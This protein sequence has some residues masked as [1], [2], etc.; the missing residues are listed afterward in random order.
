MEPRII[1]RRHRDYSEN[2]LSWRRLLDAYV[3]GDQYRN[4]TYGTDSRGLPIYNLV[5]HK[6]EYPLPDEI[7]SGVAMFRPSGSD[8]YAIATT[9]DFEFRRA[10]TP[11]PNFVGDAVELHLSSIYDQEVRR[12]VPDSVKQWHRDVN[13]RRENIDIWMSNT[14][15]PMVLV[16]GQVDVLIGH[17]VPSPGVSI[18]TRADELAAGLDRLVISV[19]LPQNV[20]WW[21]TDFW[22]NYS[23]VTILETDEATGENFVRHWHATG[24]TLYSLRNQVVSSA[25]YG[26]GRPPIIR[27][28]AKRDPIR[29]NI[30]IS[31]YG[32]VAD[33]MREYYNRDSELVLSDTVQAHPLVQGPEKYCLPDSKIPIGPNW[34]LPKRFEVSGGQNFYEGWDV[35]QFPKDGADSIRLNKQD[36]RDSADRS[37][38]L[39]K[40]A[41]S[42]GSSGQTVSQSGVSKRLDHK[43]G[44]F[45]LSK[46]ATTLERAECQIAEL[47][48]AVDSGKPLPL[49]VDGEEIEITYSRSFDLWSPEEFFEFFAD[50]RAAAQS[51]GDLPTIDG[52]ALKQ[53]VRLILRGKPDSIYAKYDEEIDALVEK[54]AKEKAMTSEGLYTIKSP[55]ETDAVLSSGSQNGQNQNQTATNLQGA[56]LTGA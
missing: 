55:A 20:L 27:L 50:L 53:G 35:L 56:N 26:F 25:D 41:G 51:C 17:P 40:P 22:G 18:R 3:G 12:R 49:R 33:H 9:D 43:A 39:T 8:Q 42:K 24:W 32:A 19:I 52:D 21:K 6:R 34:I 10:R 48:L 1:D 38:G 14:L 45:L 31:Q 13:G 30:G 11:V 7:Q 5:R 29:Q 28:F 36:M 47:F 16:L 15:A 46:I 44:D 2:V 37:A 23:E 54:N 4:A